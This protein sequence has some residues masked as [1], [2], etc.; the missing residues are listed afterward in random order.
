VRYAHADSGP[1]A[2]ADNCGEAKPSQ[3]IPIDVVNI[4]FCDR[5]EVATLADQRSNVSRYGELLAHHPTSG[6]TGTGHSMTS[7][8]RMLPLR[9]QRMDLFQ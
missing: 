9:V 4:R 5:I 2:D 6:L 3:G 7:S 1:D 8:S